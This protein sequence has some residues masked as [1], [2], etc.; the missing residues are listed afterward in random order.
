[1]LGN[2]ENS[3]CYGMSYFIMRRRLLVSD[4][5]AVHGHILTSC[6]CV[7][8]SHQRWSL[9]SRLGTPHYDL[10]STN[11]DLARGS[12][13]SASVFPT[14]KVLWP[15]QTE[16]QLIGQQYNIGDSRH[17]GKLRWLKSRFLAIPPLPSYDD[18]QVAASHGP[19][20]ILIAS[21][22]SCNAHCRNVRR[23]PPCSNPAS[24]SRR[25]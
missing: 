7:L 15:A 5:R 10:V 20:I 2:G 16:L 17:S 9:A 11:P 22:Y 12:Q 8:P 1:M 14:L 6:T 18:L 4:L 3:M 21:Q 25:C 13:S 24:Y 19:V 23:A